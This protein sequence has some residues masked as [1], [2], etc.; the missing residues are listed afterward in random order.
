MGVYL[1]RATRSHRRLQRFSGR[2][3][4]MTF[5]GTYKIADNCTGN[6]KFKVGE[7]YFEVG[8][9]AVFTGHAGRTL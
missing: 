9:N 7:A 3:E 2:P 1:Q 4:R 6:I 8:P 5:S